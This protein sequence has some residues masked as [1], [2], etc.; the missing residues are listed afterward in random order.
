MRFVGQELQKLVTIT[1]CL[2]TGI[3]WDL[4]IGKSRVINLGDWIYS[5]TYAV[6]DGDS[7]EL[8]QFEGDG[9]NIRRQTEP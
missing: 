8:K 6:F 2:V 5:F 9:A 4:Q 1:L 7:L 3:S